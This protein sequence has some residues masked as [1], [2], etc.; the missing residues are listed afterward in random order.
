MFPIAQAHIDRVV[1]V[2]DH[3]IRMAQKMLWESRA[4][5]RR[6]RR[7][8]RVRGDSVGR[9]PARGELNVSGLSSA[10]RTRPRSASSS[11][12]HLRQNLSRAPSR[13]LGGDDTFGPTARVALR[14][15]FPGRVNP[16][17]AAVGR[18]VR[19]VISRSSTGPLVIW[20]SREQNSSACRRSTRPDSGRG[21]PR[22]CPRR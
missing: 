15:P 7:L 13:G 3:A 16:H 5:R 8:R 20:T 6:T 9:L 14:R 1:L 21:R 19:R 17:L 4:A 22:P 12:P 2:S 18:Q 11:N 10:A